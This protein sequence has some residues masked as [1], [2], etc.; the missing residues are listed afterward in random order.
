MSSRGAFETGKRR[1]HIPVV[2]RIING[3]PGIFSQG[4]IVGKPSP[5]R[6]R[7][8]FALEISHPLPVAGIDEAG[9]GPWAG[10]VVAAAFI[11]TNPYKNWGNELSLIRDSKQLTAQQREKAYNQLINLPGVSYGIGQASAEE[12]D[13]LNII[14]S[15]HL[16]MQRAVSQLGPV[17]ALALVD[18]NRTPALPCPVKTVI[19]GDQISYS[20]AAASILAKVTRDR[21]MAELDKEF[22]AYGWARNAGYGTLHHR[23]ALELQGATPHHRRSYAPVARLLKLT[24]G[25]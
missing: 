4:I 5:G 8:D 6:T 20:I 16:A 19:K 10:P 21:L 13:S 17:P 11:F 24:T 23:K 18:G 2:Q 1:K 9:C 15:S 22:P 7:P 25:S 12:I 14:Q 3:R